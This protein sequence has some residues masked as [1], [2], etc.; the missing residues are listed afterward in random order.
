MTHRAMNPASP[1][2][3]RLDVA[4][5]PLAIRTLDRKRAADSIDPRLIDRVRGEF[6]EMPGLSPTLNQAAR[7]FALPQPDCDRI[8]AVLIKEGFLRH[9]PDGRY[10]LT[11]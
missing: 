9:G 10:R 6:G 11:H 3:A 8:L 2:S 1:P 5:K 7:L 4:L